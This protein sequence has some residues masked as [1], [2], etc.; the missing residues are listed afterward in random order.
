MLEKRSIV[1]VSEGSGTQFSMVV[2]GYAWAKP[3]KIVRQDRLRGNEGDREKFTARLI[4]LSR[5]KWTLV[6][7][8]CKLAGKDKASV[9]YHQRQTQR[10]RQ[11]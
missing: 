3:S 11:K 1:V 7:E 4:S 10:L 5:N 8:R 9:V 6:W 2:E